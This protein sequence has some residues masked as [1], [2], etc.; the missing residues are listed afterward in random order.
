MIDFFKRLNPSY[1]PPGRTTLSNQLL[2]Q[3]AARI[4]LKISTELEKCKFLTLALDGW[5]SSNGSSLHKF[6]D[7]AT[8]RQE[9]L[10]AL[11]DYLKVMEKIGLNKFAG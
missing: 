10:I 7:S 9:Y 6:I 4:R 5:I 8:N 11:K 1:N 2:E 3:E